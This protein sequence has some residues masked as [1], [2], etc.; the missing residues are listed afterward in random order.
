[1]DL[2]ELERMRSLWLELGVPFREMAALPGSPAGVVTWLCVD[3]YEMSYFGFD[4]DGQFLGVE[5]AGWSPREN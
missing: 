3:D 2:T 5:G 4:S 1:M